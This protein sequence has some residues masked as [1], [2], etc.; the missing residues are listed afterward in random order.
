MVANPNPL[1]ALVVD[2]DA[3]LRTAVGEVVRS[4]GHVSHLAGSRAE[5]LELARAV[6]VDYSILDVHVRSDDGLLILGNLRTIY[7]RL[8]VIFISADFTPE[9]VRRARALGAHGTLD[10]PLDV[11]D[12]RQKVLELVTSERL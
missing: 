4:L 7:A 8:P 11:A 6:P 10:K 3:G 1:H 5:A 9:T 2:D 12:L